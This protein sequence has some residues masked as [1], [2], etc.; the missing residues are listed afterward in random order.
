MQSCY[1]VRIKAIAAVDAPWL[2]HV[3]LNILKVFIKQKIL[4]RIMFVAQAELLFA[5]STDATPKRSD[6]LASIPGTGQFAKKSEIPVCLGGTN[7]ESIKTFLMNCLARRLE[8]EE[9]VKI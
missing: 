6:Y 5:D 3:M 7:S 1:P 9:K 4:E 8:S 2:I